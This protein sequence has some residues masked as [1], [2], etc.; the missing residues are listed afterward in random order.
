MKK[1]L[2]LSCCCVDVFPDK[3]TAEAGGNSLN[4]AAS[5]ALTGKAEVFLMGNIGTD[6]YAEEIKRK[7]E[8]YKINCERLYE[9]PGE[10]ASNKIYLTP[11]G[12]RQINDENWNNGVYADF[13]ISDEDE[14]FMKRLDAVA[15]TCRDPALPQLL[16]ISRESGFFL[17][18]DFMER[19]PDELW[20]EYFSAIDLFFISGK[21]EYLPLLKRWSVEFP[22]TLFTA[23]LG[24]HGSV[25]YKH[26]NEYVCEAVKVRGVID[27]TGCGDSYQ[28]AFIVDYLENKDVLSAME[29]GSESAA[30]T[31]S[32]VGA[33]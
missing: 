21:R 26:G 10:S 12:D 13:R 8:K 33:C 4:V 6:S 1:V 28:G 24:E 18:V 15:T 25:A 31:L 11:D 30:V 9:I 16:R 17:S 23:T 27:T 14:A 2:S 3:G 32:F 20:R 5:C 29:A 19:E 22:G 7:A